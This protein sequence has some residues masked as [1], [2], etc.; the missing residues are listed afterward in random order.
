M[1]PKVIKKTLGFMFFLYGQSGNHKRNFYFI[2]LTSYL[3]SD[4]QVEFHMFGFS[5][6]FEKIGE[7]A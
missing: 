6:K 3:S 5:F 2:G 1:M 7:R 4:R